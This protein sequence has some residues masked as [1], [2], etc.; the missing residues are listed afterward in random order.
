M[1]ILTTYVGPGKQNAIKS[2][3]VL[4]VCGHSTHS[5]LTPTN[6]H[7][8]SGMMY[9]LLSLDIILHHLTCFQSRLGTFYQNTNPSTACERPRVRVAV[10]PVFFALVAYG[11]CSSLFATY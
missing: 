2:N 11:Q 5:A 4:W 3:T 6:K 8:S 1:K 10:R 7:Q 9:V